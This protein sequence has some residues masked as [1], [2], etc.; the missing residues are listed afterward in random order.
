MTLGALIDVGLDP[1]WLR[2][3]P[4][5][6]GLDGVGVD[7]AKVR[8]NDLACMKVDFR[9]PM[10]SHGRQLREIQA[11][12]QR[13]A[14]PAMV[15]ELADRAFS[16]IAEAEGEVH[17]LSPED[18]HLHEL[19]AVDAILDIMGSIWGMSELGISNVY[20]GTIS[21]GDGFV[22][23][24]HGVL[25]VPAPATLKLL[26]GL[27]VRPGPEGSGELVTPTGA[28]LVRVLSTGVPPTRYVPRRSG[29]GAGSKDLPGRPNALRVILAERDMAERTLETLVMLTTDVDDMSAEHLANAADTLRVMGALDVTMSP[30]QMKKGRPGTRIEALCR[31]ADATRLEEALFSATSTIGVRRSTVER[32]ALHREDR[33]VSVLGHDVRI[34][35]STLPGGAR[36]AKPQFD[37]LRAVS[38]ATGRSLGDIS[39][40]ALSEA[41]RDK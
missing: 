38:H 12:V 35:V 5:R 3:L 2:G 32:H 1:E 21:L 14:A 11:I 4:V 8:K 13:T 7:I 25:P 33:L 22:H 9:I 20:C 28:A 23:A 31:I 26:E 30:V 19:G 6:L 34:K 10:Q 16:A 17:G 40:L 24:A 18:V 27:P 29:F 36:R 15:K 37:D 41:E 39:S